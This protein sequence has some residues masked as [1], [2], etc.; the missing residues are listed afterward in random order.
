MPIAELGYRP[1]EGKRHGAA[2]R[3]L[4]ITRTHVG[5]ALRSSKLLRRFLF[6]AW[7]PLL[8]F[9]PIFFAFGLV[10]DP[11]YELEGSVLAEITREILGRDLMNLLRQHPDVVLPAIWSVTFFVFLTFSQA[12]LTMIVVAIV[13]PALIARDV[14]SK[15]FL[16]YLS[17]PISSGEYLLGKLGVPVFFICA[18]TLAP[19]L[20]LYAISI[21]LSPN[22]SSFVNTAPILLR[23][24]F[25]A[26]VISVSLSMVILL[27]SSLTPSHR[28]A[29]FAWMAMWL[30]GE[31]SYL[32]I[33]FGGALGAGA[34]A[35]APL[36]SLRAVGVSATAT[37][38]DLSGYF[39]ALVAKA[40]ADG[41]SL[42]TL[43]VAWAREFGPESQLGAAMLE[44]A[45]QP[46]PAAALP[47][48]APLAYLATIVTLCALALRRRITKPVRI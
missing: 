21:G 30:I 20:V 17:K 23:I 37:M 24:L 25:T 6:L 9:A 11:G 13:G 32:S 15:A 43:L 7:M 44:A 10:A 2:R 4:A 40:R 19:A 3:W 12:F 33:T 45:G 27:L 29:A 5:I 18:I 31:V 22:F 16:L 39:G 47:A 42:D 41:I 38:F 36:L 28:L 14:R 8:Y 48:W 46:A 26:A 35:W 1:W 34:P